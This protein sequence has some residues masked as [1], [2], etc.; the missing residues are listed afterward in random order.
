MVA[1]EIGSD[2][3]SQR[4]AHRGMVIRR[5]TLRWLAAIL[6]FFALGDTAVLLACPM[7]GGDCLYGFLTLIAYPV[8]LSG[9]LAHSLAHFARR[10][11]NGWRRQ[12]VISLAGGLSLFAWVTVCH[13]VAIRLLNGF[14]YGE[15][16]F[17][18]R[19]LAVTLS[20]SAVYYAA[21]SII[22]YAKAQDPYESRAEPG[23]SD[24]RTNAGTGD[25]ADHANPSQSPRKT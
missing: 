10:Q 9:P 15:V 12:A 21:L 25:R 1:S 4:R 8:I 20:L 24:T 6:A 7:F 2:T 3:P 18:P 22:A 23:Q 5:A 19:L 11:P 14:D 13:V 16:L 17:R